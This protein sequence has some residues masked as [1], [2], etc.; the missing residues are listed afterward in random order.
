MN[1]LFMKH[2]LPIYALCTFYLKIKYGKLSLAYHIFMNEQKAKKGVTKDMNIDE[3]KKDR[4]VYIDCLRIFSLFLMM[5]LHV[6]GSQ[7]S[8]ISVHTNEWIIF[9]SYNSI[10]RLSVP[11]FIMI[12]GVFFLNPNKLITIKKL[13]SKY[14]LRILIALLFWSTAYALYTQFISVL[15]SQPFSLQ[16]FTKDI[17]YGHY[18]LWFLYM[19]IGLY[20]IVPFLRK[21]V[22]SKILM[23]Y[24][25]CLFF[26]YLI[27]QALIL[28]P[29]LTAPLNTI[30]QN[31]SLYFVAG[32]AG[33][34]ILGYYLAYTDM[35]QTYQRILYLSGLL[36]IIFTI[37]ISSV[38][39][40]EQQA[41]NF[42]W[43]VYLLPNILLP[44]CAVFVFFKYYV[45]KIKWSDKVLSCISLFSKLSFGM[46]L[47][48]DFFNIL[49]PAFGLTTLSYNAVLSV[50]LNTLIV[51][52][53][54]FI[55]TFVIYKIPI[56]NKYII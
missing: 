36:S 49:M 4:I 5:M 53:S 16:Q 17:V 13:F 21:I 37:V 22:E 25:L 47:I 27:L 39:S 28:I 15:K 1:P 20:L 44:S 9:N 50:P 8:I 30:Y 10:V 51:F 11:V 46:Y 55:L 2:S 43:H 23:K 3:K 41:A 56:L 35:N 34:F 54:S 40:L 52:F 48:H 29:A 19:L 7:W 24:F 42:S 45:S 14:I 6:A 18:H 33:Y 26:A 32:Y 31:I 12:S 38:L